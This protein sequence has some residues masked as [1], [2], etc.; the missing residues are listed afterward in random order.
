MKNANFYQRILA[1]IGI[2]A[3]LLVLG[4]CQRPRNQM[5]TQ[6]QNISDQKLAKMVSTI[7]GAKQYKLKKSSVKGVTDTT[8]STINPIQVLPQGYSAYVGNDAAACVQSVQ[9]I[10]REYK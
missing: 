8:S 9:A 6:F 2:V 10:P 5:I 7:R 4:A 3:S 1:G